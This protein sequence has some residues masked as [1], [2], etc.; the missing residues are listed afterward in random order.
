MSD[1]FKVEAIDSSSSITDRYQQYQKQ[2]ELRQQADNPK[3]VMTKLEQG[4]A[5]AAGK[6]MD[7]VHQTYQ[8]EQEDLCSST[9]YEAGSKPVSS[10]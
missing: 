5:E 9:G 1:G 2:E 6:D 3:K 4:M 10:F 8:E 7:R